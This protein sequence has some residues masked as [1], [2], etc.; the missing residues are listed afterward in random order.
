VDCCQ[1][2]LDPEECNASVVGFQLCPVS[3][4]LCYG[5]WHHLFDVVYK[6]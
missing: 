1:C 3:F 2:L 6:Y 5:S 4:P